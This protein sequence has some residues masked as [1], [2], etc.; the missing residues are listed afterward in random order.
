MLEVNVE[1]IMPVTEA[2]DTL[3]KIV[4]E[5]AA[6]DELYVLTVNGK[7][8]AVLVGVH[9]LEKLTGTKEEDLVVTAATLPAPTVE[10]DTSIPLNSITESAPTPPVAPAASTV[11]EQPVGPAPASISSPLNN[12]DLF[13]EDALST[14]AFD[15]VSPAAPTASPTPPAP[16]ALE[17]APPPEI[18]P[19]DVFPSTDNMATPPPAA[20]ATGQ[21]G[22]PAVTNNQNPLPAINNPLNQ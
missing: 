17:P 15:T 18:N 22:I 13:G 11:P 2:R 7:P 21:M 4:D 16:P 1:K 5:V 19:A 10:T 9:H 6:G 20:P 3:N 14:P 8:S 12:T